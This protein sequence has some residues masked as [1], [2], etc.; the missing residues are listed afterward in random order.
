[1]DMCISDMCMDMCMDMCTGMCKDM[2]MDMPGSDRVKKELPT[3]AVSHAHKN[4]L[5]HAHTNI[6]MHAHTNVYTDLPDSPSMATKKVLAR[7]S[8]H[9]LLFHARRHMS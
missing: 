1:M 8:N 7:S 3:N 4:I 2:C 5:L 6:L 9:P